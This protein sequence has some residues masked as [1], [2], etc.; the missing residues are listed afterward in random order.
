MRFPKPL[1]SLAFVA[2]C[3]ASP[4]N[5]GNTSV[6]CKE[7]F[8][9]TTTENLTVTVD[10]ALGKIT[11]GSLASNN[12]YLFLAGN[13]LTAPFATANYNYTSPQDYACWQTGGFC[14]IG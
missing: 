12:C 6:T 7:F 10:A 9:N 2:A 1:L 11:A 8:P 13:S 5:Y 14:I 3:S 4:V